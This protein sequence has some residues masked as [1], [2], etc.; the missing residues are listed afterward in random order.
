MGVSPYTCICIRIYVYNMCITCVYV[1]MC[2][3]VTR[4]VRM[5]VPPCV[6]EGQG[7]DVPVACTHA[8]HAAFS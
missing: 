2:I 3:C 8:M 1:H 7:H 4:W 6:C 5:C